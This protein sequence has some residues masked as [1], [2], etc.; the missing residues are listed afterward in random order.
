LPIG[1]ALG[2]KDDECRVP[3]CRNMA[4]S[5][6]RKDRPVSEAQPEIVLHEHATGGRYLITIEGH[7]AELTFSR[8]SQ[9]LIIVDHTGVPDELRGRNLGQM[10]VRRAV[11]V[12]RAQ[13]AKII[14]LCPFT[15]SEFRKHPEYQDVVSR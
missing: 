10:L 1:T 5:A 2:M 13:G 8:A 11:E 3:I 7:E 9:Q 12:A 6:N 15:A 14:P 4:R